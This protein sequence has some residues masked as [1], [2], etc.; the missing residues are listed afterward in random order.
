MEN[1]SNKELLDEL[2][3]ALTWISIK[4]EQNK[5]DEVDKLQ[6]KVDKL[7][8]EILSRMNW[9]GIDMMKAIKRND[10]LYDVYTEAG[11]IGVVAECQLEK[12]EKI[13]SKDIYGRNFYEKLYTN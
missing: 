6:I 10:G 4:T 3:K 8:T 9:L 2:E 7:K 13:L 1:K 12:A 11:F 5:H